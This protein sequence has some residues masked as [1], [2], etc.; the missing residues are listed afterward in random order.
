LPEGSIV[1][2]SQKW[3]TYIYVFG[4]AIGWS[5]FDNFIFFGIDDPMM[6]WLAFFFFFSLIIKF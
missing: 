3:K 2:S 6:S 5:F 4:E 1:V